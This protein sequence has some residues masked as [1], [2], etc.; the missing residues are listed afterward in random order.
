MGGGLERGGE[1]TSETIILLTLFSHL[2]SAPILFFPGRR[3]KMTN[4]LSPKELMVESRQK[5][6]Y[7]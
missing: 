5:L 3:L 6:M 1:G 2:M 7:G 4:H